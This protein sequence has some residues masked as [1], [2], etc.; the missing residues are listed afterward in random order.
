MMVAVP[1]AMVY[2]VTTHAVAVAV[3]TVRVAVEVGTAVFVRVAVDVEV[4]SA[5]LVRVAVEVDV[6]GAAVELGVG[7]PPES[8]LRSVLSVL[9]LPV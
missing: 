7:Q 9:P 4:G 3:P 8:V 1:V 5:V 6:G 2:P